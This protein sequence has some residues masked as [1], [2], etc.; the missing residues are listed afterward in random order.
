[1][2]TITERVD[3]L[4]GRYDK[5]VERGVALAAE[6][7][8]HMENG[9]ME[10]EE[11]ETKWKSIQTRQ[12][13]L[14]VILKR[15]KADLESAQAE[16]KADNI[17]RGA[18]GRVLD[19]SDETIT[20]MPDQTPAERQEM[21]LGGWL[22]QMMRPVA[23]RSMKGLE[24][25]DRVITEATAR[26]Q[27]NNEILGR[28]S[29]GKHIPFELLY[30]SRIASR[31][32]TVT[33]ADTGDQI[34]PVDYRGN[35]FIDR[36]RNQNKVM[37]MGATTLNNLVGPLSIP[38]LLTSSAID[39]TAETVAA[40]ETLLTL[41][42]LDFTPHNARYV[43]SYSDQLQLQSDPMIEQ[44]IID[45]MMKQYATEIDFTAINGDSGTDTDQPD[46]IANYT[47]VPA[48][49]INAVPD[50]ADWVGFETVADGN[51]APDGSRAYLTSPGIKGI[52]KT[53]P[54]ETGQALYPWTSQ[55]TV[56]GYRAEASNQVLTDLG[57]GVDEHQIFFGDWSELLLGFWGGLDVIVDP[58]KG[59]SQ[60]LKFV[61]GFLM[62]DVQ[63]RHAK[64]FAYCPDARLAP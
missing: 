34:V 41:G 40:T 16:E 59:L 39:W 42:T 62:M 30:S 31:Q 27:K 46:G 4:Q 56:N 44:I 36:L 33:G 57:A 52:A 45:D 15:A 2:K 6:A 26:A 58:W 24:E 5:Y 29:R 20:T 64:A 25:T 13:E 14:D 22:R 10:V 18:D 28:V 7:D 3:A 61:Y 8:A 37:Q 63:L 55:E 35:L 50:W 53:T 19:N 43:Q 51:N 21:N 9:T 32:L 54:L 11:R 23:E 17:L 12:D 47:G 38:R 48:V 1:M 60:T 49:T